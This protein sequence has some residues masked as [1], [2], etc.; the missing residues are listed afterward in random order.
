MRALWVIV[1]VCATEAA[2]AVPQASTAPADPRILSIH[3][4]TAQSGAT[5]LATVRGSGIRQATAVFLENAPLRATIEG[6]EAE[7]P[8]QTTGRNKIPMEL[9][10]LRIQVASDAKPGRYLFRLV[11]PQGVTNALPLRITEH[12]VF[13]EPA[14]AHETPET[15]VPVEKL[16]AV[17]T[18]RIQRRGETDYYAFHVE[19]GQVLT[20]EAISGLPSPGAA[21]GNAAGF[22]PSLSI[23]EPSGSWFDAKR[24]NR[25]AF[26]DEPLWV[27]GQ[28]TDAY[29]VHKF[30]KAGRYFLRIEAFSGQGGPDYSYQLKI[31]PGEAPQDRAPAGKSWEERA[32]SCSLSA[33]RLNELAERGGRPQDQ[34]SI[35]TYRA[36]TND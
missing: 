27:L 36:G 15:A 13:A 26:N 14:G 30:E 31:L 5:S 25:I 17:F 2:F 32:F 10:R 35:E 21:G 24:L 22:D 23:F 6:A 8:G 1:C 11:T 16:P 29:L 33:N 19:A 28:P 34:K 3:P 9:V 20:F 18:G 4:V 7:P 12:P